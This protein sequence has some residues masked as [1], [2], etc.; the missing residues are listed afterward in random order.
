MKNEET[1]L[2]NGNGRGRRRRKRKMKKNEDRWA[3]EIRKKRKKTNFID[4]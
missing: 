2:T 3:P 1:K 4:C